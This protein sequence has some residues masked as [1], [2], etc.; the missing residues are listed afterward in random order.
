MIFPD[1]SP[2][3]QRIAFLGAQID[4]RLFSCSGIL[5][6]YQVDPDGTNFNKIVD[7]V[8]SSDVSLAMGMLKWAPDNRRVGVY[9]GSADA[10]QLKIVDVI[11]GTLTAF[12]YREG[13]DWRALAWS[14]NG[15]R[16]AIG[17]TPSG[18]DPVIASV[19]LIRQTFTT[20]AYGRLPAWGRLS[21]SP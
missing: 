5:A 2:D 16:L 6:V 20:L 17:Y 21:P 14:P 18:S 1:V 3:G 8:S 9:V 12:P 19:D 11:S 10:V 13:M 4:W 15:T 7:V